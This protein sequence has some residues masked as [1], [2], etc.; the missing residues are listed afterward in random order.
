MRDRGVT[1]WEK[2]IPASWMPPLGSW[3]YWGRIWS[4]G[5]NRK[6][7][8]HPFS[9][10][11]GQVC[12]N[13]GNPI[14]RND[15]PEGIPGQLNQENHEGAEPFSHQTVQFE[16]LVDEVENKENGRNVGEKEGGGIQ[17]EALGKVIL[18][19]WNFQR[20]QAQSFGNG[21]RLKIPVVVRAQEIFPVLEQRNREERQRIHGE[22][23][24]RKVIP[25]HL[26]LR[27]SFPEKQLK[28]NWGNHFLPHL[29]QFLM[30]LPSLEQWLG[31]GILQNPAARNK[32]KR[33]KR[34]K[35]K[36]KMK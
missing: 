4:H 16:L 28:Y 6:S 11:T 25:Q 10:N 26:L 2:A 12:S 27:K 33:N 31:R 9:P 24:F 15:F 17:T 32:R 8:K 20:V 3:C 30:A 1:D 23:H 5:T 13:V 22:H 34:Y 21:M 29:S 35:Q 7:F 36:K 14:Q 19:S 18:G